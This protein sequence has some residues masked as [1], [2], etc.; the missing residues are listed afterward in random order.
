M[1]DKIKIVD[2]VVTFGGR[3]VQVGDRVTLRTGIVEMLDPTDEHTPIHADGLG[4]IRASTIT[5]LDPCPVAPDTHLD[6]DGFAQEI[7]TAR[8]AFRG[9]LVAFLGGD[10]ASIV[11][12]IQAVDDLHDLALEGPAEIETH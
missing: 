5:D 6:V 4:W 8:A 11:A 7:G 3:A 10:M 1:Q 9:R 2:G 12:L